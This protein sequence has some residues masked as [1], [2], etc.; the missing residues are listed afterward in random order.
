MRL[1]QES[2]HGQQQYST[3]RLEA[4]TDGVFAIA[5]TLLV[6]DLSVNKLGKIVTN[7]ELWNA[8]YDMWPSIL[9]FA[10][11]FGLLCLLW[12]THTRQ[13][14]FI[15]H[16]DT[17]IVIINSLR[18]LG[19]VLIP[20]TTSLNSAYTDLLAGRILMPL[21]FFIVVLIGAIQWHYVTSRPSLT[22]P[23]DAARIK[24]SR[25][26]GIIATVIAALVVVAAIWFG[27]FAF[28]LF[29]LNNVVERIVL[30]KDH[31]DDK[32]PTQS[33]GVDDHAGA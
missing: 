3:R 18:L 15:V 12:S 8:L 27:S 14:E 23:M 10:I 22:T 4:F 11:S 25:T 32:P 6:L 7:A 30:G 31:G 29:F 20:F 33:G 2:R 26:G 5:A 19:V 21:N 17:P 16:I 1:G 9:S 13:F 24:R 28:F